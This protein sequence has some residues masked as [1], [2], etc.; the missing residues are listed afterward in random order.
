VT[1]ASRAEQ[2]LDALYWRDEILQAMYWMRGEGIDAEVGAARL[3]EFLAADADHVSVQMRLLE[4]DGYLECGGESRYTLTPAGVAE[5][6]RSFADEFAAL[7]HTAHYECAPGC[8]C[9]DPDHV[10]EPCPS[11]PQPKRG[12]PPP[13]GPSE[14]GEDTPRGA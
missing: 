4:S 1:L 9:H 6:G 13:D 7:T 2:A 3:A 10:G 5:G 11:Q 8:W 12:E 14:P